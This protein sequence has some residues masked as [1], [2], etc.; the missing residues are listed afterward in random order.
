MANIWLCVRL[1]SGNNK[2]DCYYSN[3][4]EQT[5]SVQI[6]LSEGPWAGLFSRTSSSAVYRIRSTKPLV[7]KMPSSV[8]HEHPRMRAF[9]YRQL[10]T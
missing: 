4:Y 1:H 2:P 3:G 9:S 8:R 6:C 7:N 5:V 10:I